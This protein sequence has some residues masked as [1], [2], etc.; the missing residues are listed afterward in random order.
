MSSRRTAIAL[1]V[2][3][4]LI[5]LF[6]TR[7]I[8]DVIVN[9]SLTAFSNARRVFQQSSELSGFEGE[10]IVASGKELHGITMQKQSPSSRHLFSANDNIANPLWSPEKD[11]IAFFVT[12]GVFENRNVQGI[13]KYDLAVY[14]IK[15]NTIETIASDIELT[16][17]LQWSS[18][19][20]QLLF[21]SDTRFV[22]GIT[23]HVYLYDRE[24]S[25]TLIDL[26]TKETFNLFR[27][28]VSF[29]TWSPDQ[30]HIAFVMLETKSVVFQPDDDAVEIR[31]PDVSLL[32]LSNETVSRLTNDTNI[33]SDL[34]WSPENTA[35]AFLSQTVHSVDFT[36][37]VLHFTNESTKADT[38]NSSDLSVASYAWS[39][40]GKS[41]AFIAAPTYLDP[42]N[43]DYDV[44]MQVY[45]FSIE[46]KSEIALT[47]EMFSKRGIGWSNNG[48]MIIFFSANPQKPLLLNTI[49]LNNQS[50]AGFP[51]VG[52]VFANDDFD[53]R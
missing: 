38:I 44:H 5:V 10:I 27:G 32:D 41:I 15:S 24:S 52:G 12:S 18:D 36:L 26:T 34:H 53:I 21:L 19:G 25:I 39:P 17:V 46:S 47:D 1:T 13:T 20:E 14:D 9:V 31:L 48:D 4:L 45:V 43:W 7:T 6:G 2:C 42:M 11:K 28:L 23:P 35:I 49:N 50:K 16:S 33:E 40:N 22:D 30:K 8:R 3:I 29:A 37:N 51:I